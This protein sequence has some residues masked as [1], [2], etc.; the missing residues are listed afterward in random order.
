M[1]L[2]WA[3]RSTPILLL[4]RERGLKAK[5]FF[6][7][8]KGKAAPMRAARIEMPLVQRCD[9]KLLPVGGAWIGN[10]RK[11][12]ERSQAWQKRER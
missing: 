5:D 2:C 11:N 4:D 6:G 7:N 8:H 3:G 9:R 1:L 12:S 10:G